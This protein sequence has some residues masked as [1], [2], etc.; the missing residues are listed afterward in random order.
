M[1]RGRKPK[2]PYCASTRTVSKG[3]RKTTTMGSRKLRV[4]KDCHR[5][6]TIGRKVAA[7]EI[8]KSATST[9]PS[10]TVPVVAGMHSTA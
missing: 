5:K 9:K 10:S 7:S 1:K 6:F 4:C 8:R 3:V 2:C